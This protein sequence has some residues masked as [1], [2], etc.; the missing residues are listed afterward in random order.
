M[1]M[2]V[3]RTSKRS[4]SR[5]AVTRDDHLAL[6]R[7]L[8][9]VADQ[10]HQHLAQPPVVAAHGGRHVVGDPRRE[11]EPA[12]VRARGEQVADV[13]DGLAHVEVDRVELE[14]AGLDLREVEDVVDDRQQRAAGAAH[15]L[16]EAA[17]LVVERR[18]EQQVGHAEHAVHRRADLV[19]DVGQELGLQ[20]RRLERLVA[21]DHEF[22]LGPAALDELAQI[23]GDRQHRRLELRV[24]RVA[25]LSASSIAPRQRP[26]VRIGSARIVR[27]A[28]A[29]SFR[30]LEAARPRLTSA[31]PD[32][33]AAPTPRRPGPRRARRSA[34]RRRPRGSRRASL[35]AR[36]HGLHPQDAALEQPDVARA[37]RARTD[38]A[39]EVRRGALDVRGLRQHAAGGVLGLRAPG[40]ARGRRRRGRR[41]SRPRSARRAQRGDGVVDQRVRAVGARHRLPVH[42]ARPAVLSVSAAGEPPRSDHAGGR[43]GAADPVSRRGWRRRR[44]S[45]SIVTI[46]SPTESRIAACWLRQPF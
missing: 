33:R 38:G 30:A 26:S 31:H 4:P 36:P 29:A 1:P 19:A 42:L 32:G 40:R 20:P 11:L 46:P 24:A 39:H 8:D 10:V 41:T 25:A 6:V 14:L 44:P 21:R 27:N 5:V 45:R 37:S 2:P 13:G 17:L 34:G 16:G 15:G 9:R 35:V 7:E 43:V 12:L 28:P 23:A 22:L 18:V 3:S